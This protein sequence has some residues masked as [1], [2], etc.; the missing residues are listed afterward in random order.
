MI[1][2]ADGP[3]FTA[4]FSAVAVTAAQDVFEI[5]APSTSRVLIREIRIGQYSDFGDAQAEILSVLVLR[6]YTTTGSG[7]TTLTPANTRGHASAPASASVVKANNT[8]VAANGSPVTLLADSF[9][10]Q[11]GFRLNYAAEDAIALGYLLE[12]SQRLV[13]RITAPVDALTTNGTITY[14]EVG[15]VVL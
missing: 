15:K 10:V 9:N 13:V 4:T 11:F 14:Q 2:S 1:S 3:I 5:T 6:G 7:G 12:P 8:T